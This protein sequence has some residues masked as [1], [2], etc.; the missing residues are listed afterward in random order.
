MSDS[1]F[2]I[3]DR[4]RDASP[5]YGPGNMEM[6]QRCVEHLKHD[7][8]HRIVEKFI[9]MS[10]PS[11]ILDDE[12]RDLIKLKLGQRNGRTDAEKGIS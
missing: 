5:Q 10:F 11:E 8:D 6:C 1:R 2:P 9:T 3:L 7:V 12:L 4:I